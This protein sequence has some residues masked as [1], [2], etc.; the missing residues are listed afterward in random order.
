[1]PKYQKPVNMTPKYFPVDFKEMLTHKQYAQKMP[2]KELTNF[3][4]QS[5]FIETLLH[6]NSDN[7]WCKETKNITDEDLEKEMGDLKSALFGMSTNLVQMS[8]PQ[9]LS[10][11][12]KDERI[13][14]L[15]EEILTGEISPTDK[16]SRVLGQ[17]PTLGGIYQ[18]TFK[19]TN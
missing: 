8:R 9:I 3:Y 5:D 18:G 17:V 2:K 7:F 1:M 14:R 11:S 13:Q 16:N 19:K 15:T 4:F 6:K 12:S 10:A